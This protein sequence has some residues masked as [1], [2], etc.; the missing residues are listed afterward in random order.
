M[1]EYDPVMDTWTTKTSMNIRGGNALAFN[2]VDGLAYV[3]GAGT[4]IEGPSI[5]QTYDPAKDY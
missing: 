3:V 1:E 5:V 4:T 2:A